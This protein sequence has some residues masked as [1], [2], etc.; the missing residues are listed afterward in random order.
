MSLMH[1]L[2]PLEEIEATE[3]IEEK[4]EAKGSVSQPE[5]SA[6]TSSAATEPTASAPVAPHTCPVRHPADMAH[7]SVPAT[8][9]FRASPVRS[10]DGL[11]FLWPTCG[12]TADGMDDAVRKP[13]SSETSEHVCAPRPPP[14]LAVHCG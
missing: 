3:T 8:D 9:T 14:D 4:T 5:V 6:V 1:Y 11:D 13:A 2:P 10:K 12:R 7:S